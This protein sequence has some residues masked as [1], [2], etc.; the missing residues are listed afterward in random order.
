[1]PKN[2]SEVGYGGQRIRVFLASSWD[3]TSPAPGLPSDWEITQKVLKLMKKLA[4]FDVINQHNHQPRRVADKVSEGIDD[5]DVV[6]CVFTKRLHVVGPPETYAPSPYVLTEA[7]YALG[8]Y[9]NYEGTKRVVGFFEEGIDFSA[10]G[11][12]RDEGIDL[13]PFTRDKFDAAIP[14]F[15]EYLSQLPVVLRTGGLAGQQPLYRPAYRQLHVKKTVRMH[16]SGVG[17]TRMRCQVLILDAH[18]LRERGGIPHRIWT[19]RSK[20]P[21][22][23]QMLD[24]QIRHRQAEAVFTAVIV[25]CNYRRLN[26]PPE[27]IQRS[28]TDTSI[29]FFLVPPEGLNIRDDDIIE[30]QYAWSLPGSFATVEEELGAVAFDEASLTTSHGPIRQAELV[31]E[32]EREA[33]GVRRVSPFS[34]EPYLLISNQAG[35]GG[36]ISEPLPFPHVDENIWYLTYA[37]SMREFYG[38]IISRW[39]PVSRTRWLNRPTRI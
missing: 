27:V 12:Y 8:R 23:E 1:M 26:V 16:R 36:S 15:K 31:L 18:R 13:E 14:R 34:K 29:E 10:L 11:L 30:Y 19:I 28:R 24:V 2:N 4:F 25:S 17:I 38:T 9:R 35:T 22:L 32:F 5:A 3:K 39:R 6:V 37:W 33:R 7:G 21:P 20:F